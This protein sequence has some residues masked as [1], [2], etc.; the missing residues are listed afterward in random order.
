MLYIITIFLSAFL[1]FQVQPV[2]AKM[3]L[4]LFGGGAAV[5]TS[6]LLFFQTFLLLGYLYAHGLG[7]LT[8]LR[9]QI[10][11]HGALLL[12]SL[13]FMPLASVDINAIDV[14]RA[15]LEQILVLLLG[16][17]GLPYLLLSSTAPL[18]QRWMSLAEQGKTPYKLYSVSNTGS[19]LALVSYP[20][21]IEPALAMDSQTLMWSVGFGAFVLSFAVLAV[22]LL[23]APE[24]SVEKDSAATSSINK[25]DILLWIGLSAT[26]VIL[27]I[28]T[29]SAMTQNIP[30]MPFLWVLPLSI[31]LLTFIISF[32]SPR[33]YVRWY[34]FALFAIC[35]FAA[36]LMLFIGS[37][38]DIFS[39]VGMYS[40]ILFSACMICH[41][42]TGPGQ[43]RG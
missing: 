38:F 12:V 3:I 9:Q 14:S 4:P 5:W 43:A 10:T 6:C 13:A 23:K 41:G 11:V 20:F 18:V 42:E 21:V 16:A 34:W 31:Y 8:S 22:K 19:L 29:T 2:I 33:W 17:I 40:L 15:P 24:Q 35:S 36:V 26:G 28:S 37:Q 7:K 39:L 32:H 1:V 30:P 25:L 27:L